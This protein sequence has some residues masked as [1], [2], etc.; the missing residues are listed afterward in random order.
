MQEPL[1][2]P[3][4]L[5]AR[6]GIMTI[7]LDRWRWSGKGPRFFKAGRVVKYRVQDIEMYEEQK[8]RQSTA[9]TSDER[10]LK[11]LQQ[12]KLKKRK[13]RFR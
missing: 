9:C 1:M 13:R 11:D 7:T 10:L 2:S 5:A 3:E 8:S 6:W 4:E 12:A